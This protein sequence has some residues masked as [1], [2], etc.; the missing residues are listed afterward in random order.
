MKKWQNAEVIELDVAET[1][2]PIWY[3]CIPNCT[4]NTTKVTTTIPEQTP[5]VEQT[6]VVDLKS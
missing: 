2:C 6:T 3:W 4:P 1:S 5:V